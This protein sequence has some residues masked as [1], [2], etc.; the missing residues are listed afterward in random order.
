MK[1]LFTETFRTIFGKDSDITE[2]RCDLIN[3]LKNNIKNKIEQKHNCKLDNIQN[4]WQIRDLHIEVSANEV[5]SL[6]KKALSETDEEF[7]CCELLKADLMSSED[8]F[9]IKE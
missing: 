2:R 6:Y 9:E 3:K 8:F 4:G 7:S 1:I 5:M